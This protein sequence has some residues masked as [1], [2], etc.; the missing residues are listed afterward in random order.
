[1][2]MNHQLNPAQ[3]IP[4]LRFKGKLLAKLHLGICQNPNLWS[5]MTLGSFAWFP[6]ASWALLPASAHLL[7]RLHSL[8]PQ[9]QRSR[10][11]NQRIHETKALGK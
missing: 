1:M 3:G 11:N 9:G 8:R 10:T 7:M 4:L 6:A 5:Q 2:Q